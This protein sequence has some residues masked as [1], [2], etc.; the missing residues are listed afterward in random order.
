[1]NNSPLVSIIM[2]AY[3]SELYIS[4]SIGSVI[5]Q[6]Y[7]NWELLVIDDGSTDNTGQIIKEFQQ[8]DPRIKYFYQENARQAKARNL[9]I[10][11]SNGELIA[12]LDSDDL[13]LPSKLELSINEFLK[14]QQDVLFTNAYVFR[15][16]E[17][18]SE[19]ECL[20]DMGVLDK[21]FS[22]EQGLSEFLYQNRI[23]ILT[24]IAKKEAILKVNGFNDKN[25]SGTAEDYELWLNLLVNGFILRGVS[26]KLSLYRLHVNSTS[27][28]NNMD[29][30]VVKMFQRFFA[31]HSGLALKYRKQTIHWLFNIL[32][33]ASN[34]E[35]IISIFNKIDLEA[36]SIDIRFISFI[37]Y[38]NNILPFYIQKKNLKKLL[39][40]TKAKY[41]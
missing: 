8:K 18:L 39:R 41:E 2:P 14:G 6:T 5:A 37:H 7:T 28:I 22:G 13:W 12:F 30:R 21:E 35:E 3:N 23:P 10:K 15:D 31:E 24:V 4:E 26:M 38:T 40:L 25:I 29:I 16:T 9:G 36:L 34:K 19:L 11:N 27:S 33:Q 17:Q 32:R 20:P 1:M